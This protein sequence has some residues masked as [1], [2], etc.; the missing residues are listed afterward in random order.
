PA[1]VVS[2]ERPRRATTVPCC[3]GLTES[4]AARDRGTS[5]DTA[6]GSNTIPRLDSITR[7]KANPLDPHP[8]VPPNAEPPQGLT[9]P[10]QQFHP[11]DYDR[12]FDFFR[13]A[14]GTAGLSSSAP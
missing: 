12:P 13:R 2:A 4:D 1:H 9:P 11:A 8:H 6:G 5:S 10:F 3:D 7:K 14:G